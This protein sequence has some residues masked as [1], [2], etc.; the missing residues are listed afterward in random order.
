MSGRVLVASVICLGLAGCADKIAMSSEVGGSGSRGIV[1]SVTSPGSGGGGTSGLGLGGEEGVLGNVL[2]TDPVG[3]LL[4][5]GLGQGNAVSAILGSSGG[6]GLIP[7]AAAVLAGE[8]GAEITGL[9]IFGAGG[10]VADLAGTDLLGGAL[11][12]SG[13][14]GASLAGGNDGLLGSILDAQGVGAPLASALQPLTAALPGGA[15]PLN[16]VTDGLSSVPALGVTG[17]GGLVADLI[18]VDLVG[19]LVGTNNPL[20]GGNSGLVGNLVPVSEPPLGAIG[21]AATGVLGIV[22]G[23]QSSP[24]AGALEPAMPALGALLGG[25]NNTVG[26]V[27]APGQQAL[28]SAPVLGDLLGAPAAPTS[29]GAPGGVLE[30]VTGVLSSVPVV[31]EALAPVTGALGGLGGLLGRR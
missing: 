31:G 16:T 29:G 6:T 11:D 30:P 5:A 8:P 7:S 18:G 1:T 14:L 28:G 23:S 9:G 22:A 2:G 15:L 27:A 4:E 17:T 12:T 25:V 26:G 21:D 13:V 24:L 19:N 3:G 20:A 10:L